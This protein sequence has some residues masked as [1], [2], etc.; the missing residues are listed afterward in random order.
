MIISCENIADIPSILKIESLTKENSVRLLFPI[1]ILD[2]F[3]E[4]VLQPLKEKLLDCTVFIG[5]RTK[6]DTMISIIPVIKRETIAKNLDV[7]IKIIKDYIY[8]SNQLINN[9]TDDNNWKNWEL[10]YK[11]PPHNRYENLVTNQIVETCDYKMTSI[12]QIDPYFFGEFI[13]SSNYSELK[14]LIKDTYHDTLR[15]LDVVAET[16]IIEPYFVNLKKIL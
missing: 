9:V 3:E 4:K 10:T 16:K 7:I 11:H 15:I 2:K 6:V 12:K 1:G 5:R 8:I 14:K 13:Q